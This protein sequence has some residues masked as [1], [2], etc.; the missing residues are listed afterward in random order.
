MALYPDELSSLGIPFAGAGPEISRSRGWA[1]RIGLVRWELWKLPEI[2]V[3][4]GE[5]G[6]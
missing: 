2:G 3:E 4:L 6:L 1:K 5:P